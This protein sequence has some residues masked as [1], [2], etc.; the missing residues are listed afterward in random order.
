MTV[1]CS[2]RLCAARVIVLLALLAVPTAG[3]AQDR[4]DAGPSRW[5]IDAV[6]LG[7][8][9]VLVGVA[10]SR[11]IFHAG[12][13]RLALEAAL[14]ANVWE[15]NE[16]APCPLP[17][18][19]CATPTKPPYITDLRTV[20]LRGEYPLGATWRVVGSTGVAAGDWRRPPD[21][22][23][24]VLDLGLGLARASRSGAYA[25]ELRGHRIQ[26]DAYPTYAARVALRLRL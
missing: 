3:L 8:P 7:G 9:G 6:A 23:S 20:A 22:K 21:T 5:A 19:P 13:F 11:D 4:V 1:R 17:P 2:R 10:L 26:T 12:S 16:F 25:F 18:S 24:V 15:D 14:L